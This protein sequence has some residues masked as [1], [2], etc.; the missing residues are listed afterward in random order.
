MT[1]PSKTT[2]MTWAL[3]GAA[4]LL[5]VVAALVLTFCFFIYRD[6]LAA[7]RPSDPLQDITVQ[8][9]VD[10]GALA[11]FFVVCAFVAAAIYLGI[12]GIGR[13]TRAVKR[14]TKICIAAAMT[15]LVALWGGWSYYRGSQAEHPDLTF[16]DLLQFWPVSQGIRHSSSF[17]LYEGLP[18]QLAEAKLVASEIATKKTFKMRGFSFYERPLPITRE[19]ADTLQRLVTSPDTFWSSV[20]KACGGFHPDYCLAWNDGGTTYYLMLCFGCHEMYF[21]DTKH[22]FIADVRH[23]AFP[24]FKDILDKYRAQRPETK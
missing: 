18:H 19:D 10:S 3:R 8:P 1:P 24:Q 17:T 20:P 11:R 21:Y 5:A 22:E 15:V 14:K 16:W 12:A 7:F 6:G 4:L 9:D 13:L 23:N 2:P